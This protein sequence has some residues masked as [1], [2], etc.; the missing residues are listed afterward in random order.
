MVTKGATRSTVPFPRNGV[1]R[2]IADPTRRAILDLLRQR[3]L[4]AGEVAKNFRVSR[5]AVA[6][7]MRVLRQAGLLRE[8]R[9][10]TSRLYS[11]DGR[12][13]REVDNWLAPY[14]LFWAARLID[15]KHAVEGTVGPQARPLRSPHNPERKEQK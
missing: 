7:H 13:L 2:A 4:S 3:E 1:F 8:R 9:Q 5:P 11:L 15:L 10:A 6:K 14:R 12:A